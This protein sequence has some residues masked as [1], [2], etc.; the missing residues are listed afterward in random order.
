M[1]LYRIA[2]GPHGH[3]PAP[4]FRLSRNP[5]GIYDEGHRRG[6]PVRGR[7]RQGGKRGDGPTTTSPT[8]SREPDHPHTA[9]VMAKRDWRNAERI[10]PALVGQKTQDGLCDCASQTVSKPGPRHWHLYQINPLPFFTAVAN[11]YGRLVHLKLCS[12][13]I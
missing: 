3:C 8:H 6:P 12:L 1:E 7:Y 9:R 4:R 11:E 13:G 10:P 2:S 5:R